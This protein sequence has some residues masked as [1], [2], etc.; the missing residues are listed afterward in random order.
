MATKKEIWREGE[1]DR[2]YLIFHVKMKPEGMEKNSWDIY[3]FVNQS[4]LEPWS[5][6]CTG[7][8]LNGQEA[9]NNSCIQERSKTSTHWTFGEIS[10]D[11]LCYWGF[12]FNC[13]CPTFLE[14]AP[15]FSVNLVLIL[16]LNGLPDMTNLIGGIC[17]SLCV[18]VSLRSCMQEL[19]RASCPFNFLP[20]QKGL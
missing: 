18:N 19:L 20:V 16:A 5:P 17:Y 6:F 13:S 2:R 12:P 8:K 1:T 7:R 3:A 11:P 9:R 14:E 15:K 10:R 4:L